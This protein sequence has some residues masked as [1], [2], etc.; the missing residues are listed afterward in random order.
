MKDIYLGG[1]D[2]TPARLAMAETAIQE[3]S[4]LCPDA[5]DPHLAQEQMPFIRYRITMA[6]WLK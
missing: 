4:R 2:H 5:G 1:Y 6:L 3:A